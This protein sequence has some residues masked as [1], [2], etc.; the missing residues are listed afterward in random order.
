MAQTDAGA[1]I[2]ALTGP[3]RARRP[4]A[5]AAAVVLI[6]AS[7]ATALTMTWAM[8]QRFETAQAI[9]AQAAHAQTGTHAA[10]PQTV[11]AQAAHPPTAQPAQPPTPQAAHAQA[12][13][14]QP[15]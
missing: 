6:A 5:A 8:H 11:Y 10:H 1:R 4:W 12:A 14:A 9:Y 15:R 3:P 2:R 7:G 13:H